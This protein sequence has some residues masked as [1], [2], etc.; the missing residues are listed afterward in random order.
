MSTN[1]KNNYYFVA[2][3]ADKDEIATLHFVMLAITLLIDEIAT[4][5]FVMSLLSQ[6]ARNAMTLLLALAMTL[7]LETANIDK[8]TKGNL[9][10]CLDC[11]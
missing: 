1:N 8:K 11:R 9:E 4:L 6:N 3:E 5:H 10:G 2:K 7:L